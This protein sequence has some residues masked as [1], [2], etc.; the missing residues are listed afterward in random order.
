MAKVGAMGTDDVPAQNQPGTTTTTTTTQPAQPAKPAT[1]A[2][3]PLVKP[4]PE[5]A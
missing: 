1:P 5:K 2:T 3:P 4:E